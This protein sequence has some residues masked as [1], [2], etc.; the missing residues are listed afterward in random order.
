MPYLSNYDVTATGSDFCCKLPVHDVTSS[1]HAHPYQLAVLQRPER[2]GRGP[3][4]GHPTAGTKR[5]S[6]LL[7]RRL[8]AAGST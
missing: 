1:P 5:P 3:L 8:A 4:T 2:R 7:N 6:N